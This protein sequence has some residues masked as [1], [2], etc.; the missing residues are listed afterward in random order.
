MFKKIAFLLLFIGILSGC[1]DN[2]NN[3][4]NSRQLTIFT[5]NDVHAQLENYAKIKEI[6]DA[7]RAEGNVLFLSAGDN[8]SGNPVVDSHEE[9]GYPLV[10]VMNRVG[11]DVAVI[12]N[13]EFDYGEEHLRNRIQQAEFDFICA[14]V[15]TEGSLIPQPQPFTKITIGDIDVVILGLVETNGSD[16]ETIPSTHPWRV[17]NLTFSRPETVV[18]QHA[19]LKNEQDADVYIALTHIGHNGN[20]QVL[21][22][23]QLAEKFPYFDLIIGGHSHRE[24]DTIVNDIPVYQTGSYLHKLGRIDLTIK[25]KVVT[26]IKYTLIDLDAYQGQDSEL[27][28]LITEYGDQPYLNE[29][30]GYS[31]AYHEKSGVGCFYTDALRGKMNVDLTFQNT[32]GVRSSLN[33]GDITKREIYQ[34]SPFNNG[35]VIYEMTVADVKTFLT[36]SQSG[37]YYSG[38]GISQSGSNVVIKDLGG[39]MLD[40]NQVLK[41]GVND[42]IPAV[43]APYFPA[44]GEIQ[45]LTAAET[46]IAY[47][48]EIDDQV[49]TPDCTRYFRYSN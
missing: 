27:A 26:S 21:G 44:L 5:V 8:F 49:N 15:D 3:P 1:Q 48:V 4:G 13:H 10:D 14:N 9:K 40:D 43:H 38:L 24:I 36:G 30:I 29:V 17:Q 25:N 18:T 2:A 12:G 46:I 28:A 41:V 34:I 42:Y 47:L 22:D 35:T 32:G 16:N 37:F 11:I 31:H 39:N 19:D 20:D 23:F 6:V 33:E 7:E 45:S